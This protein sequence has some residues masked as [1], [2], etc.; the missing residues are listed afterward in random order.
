M[1]EFE[2]A[3]Y[4][5][6]RQAPPAVAGPEGRAA[7]GW[8]VFEDPPEEDPVY[9]GLFCPEC[10]P[11][12]ERERERGQERESAGPDVFPESWERGR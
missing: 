10:R 6:G 11:I 12:E 8:V 1:T 3:C 7:Q 5:C 4:R 9:G 2:Q